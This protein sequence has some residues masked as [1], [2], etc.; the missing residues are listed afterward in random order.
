V[1]VVALKIL[2]S[3][4]QE[5]GTTTFNDRAASTTKIFGT[6]EMGTQGKG[7]NDMKCFSGYSDMKECCLSDKFGNCAAGPSA[8]VAEGPFMENVLAN[9]GYG[10]KTG[11]L[12]C[13]D[14]AKT[15]LCIDCCDQTRLSHDF[16]S[17]FR[18][19]CPKSANDEGFNK[20]MGEQKAGEVC[21]DGIENQREDGVDCGGRCQDGS[22]DESC[23]V[24]IKEGEDPTCEQ[25]CK[26]SGGGE[27]KKCG[28]PY[29]DQTRWIRNTQ[30]GKCYY[31]PSGQKYHFP[32]CPPGSKGL[33]CEEPVRCL[34]AQGFLCDEKD[35]GKT[36]WP[37]DDPEDAGNYCISGCNEPEVHV[38]NYKL[39]KWKCGPKEDKASSASSSTSGGS[40]TFRFARRQTDADDSEVTC[41]LEYDPKDRIGTMVGYDL[42]LLVEERRNNKG[43]YWV[44]VNGCR[45]YPIF[46]GE[47]DHT[48]SAKDRAEV[49]RHP[50][51]K[52]KMDN[53]KAKWE[54][55]IDKGN[56]DSLIQRIH[57][58]NLVPECPTS[59]AWQ[60]KQNDWDL[61]VKDKWPFPTPLDK[62]Q[63]QEIP[64]PDISPAYT[65]LDEQSLYRDKGTDLSNPAWY[66][67]RPEGVCAGCMQS[68]SLSLL[69]GLT[70]WMMY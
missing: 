47:I 67:P 46:Q 53:D 27:K 20:F 45:A 16:Y 34:S 15:G 32:G 56:Y 9:A 8:V 59:G 4:A 58:T 2:I 24:N 51:T 62:A 36:C 57:V 39:E 19:L 14:H 6:F 54:R 40:Y 61:Y 69:G 26:D 65:T 22:K 31:E 13:Q 21:N 66:T 37:S 5:T 25:V 41:T 29:P 43:N 48:I 68:V 10:T 49:M 30:G 60:W 7:V 42:V 38:W 63:I 70:L 17:T 64:E 23:T 12:N 1:F 3:V 44:G 33:Y 11:M 35:I 52:G 50:S 28:G 18:L 55:S